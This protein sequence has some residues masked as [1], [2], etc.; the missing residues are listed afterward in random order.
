[1]DFFFRTV[2]RRTEDRKR[3]RKEG[4]SVKGKKTNIHRISIVV[5]Q[6]YRW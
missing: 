5:Q 3:E 1:M 4:K 6:S 2:T